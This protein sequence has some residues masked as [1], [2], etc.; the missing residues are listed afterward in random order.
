MAKQSDFDRFISNIEP[1]PS[2]VSYI[3][4][5]Q[6]TLRE[7][8]RKHKK[9]SNIYVDSFLS[10]SYAK[11]TSIRPVKGDKKR[12]VDIIVVTKYS[13]YDDSS[14]VLTELSSVLQESSIYGH[15][16]LQH[17]SI[18]I[19]LS[20]ISIDVV[21]VIQDEDDNLYYVCDSETGEWIKTDPKGHKTWSTQINQDNNSTYKPLVKVF[22]WWR[23]I[24]CPSDVRYPKGITLE[25]IIA[26][27]IGDIE[28]STEDLFI[29]TIQNIISTYK[30]DFADKDIVPY[31][32]DPSEKIIDNDLLFGYSAEDFSKFIYKLSE[33]AD[34]LN[35]EGT[36]NEIWRRILGEDFPQDT[37][38]KSSHAFTVCATATHR[39]KPLWPMTH[40]GAAFIGVKVK[41]KNGNVIEYVNNGTPLDKGLSLQFQVYTG[42]KKPFVVKWQITNTGEDARRAG[43]MRGNFENSDIGEMGKRETTSYSG[44]HSVQCFIIKNGICVA[45]SKDYI[46]NI[47]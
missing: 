3:S 39:Q 15:L 13:L 20:K 7:Y 6:N 32:P 40:G 45:K 41:D 12:D 14:R 28:H 22:K 38:A 33:H 10:G 35:T 30:E 29:S 1:S 42:V 8:L 26:D 25:K 24:N 37:S 31:I 5:V 16:E 46:I 19:E 34:L 23:R 2:T 44:S 43:C 17:H 36:G 47:K 9:Y 27:N 21:P 11:H 18:G 4:S